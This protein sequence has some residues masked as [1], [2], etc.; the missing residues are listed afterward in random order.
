MAQKKV[1][2][3]SMIFDSKPYLRGQ[4]TVVGKKEGQ[5]P[6]ADCFDVILEDNTFGEKTWEKAE[7]KMLK[8][9]MSRAI[10]RADLTVTNVHRFEIHYVEERV[11][12]EKV[13]K[14]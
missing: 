14:L 1:G 12:N 10:K 5:G 4:G 6:L 8:E 13:D 11:L 3:Q 2:N 7:S 9:A